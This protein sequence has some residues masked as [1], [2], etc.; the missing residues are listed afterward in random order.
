MKHKSEHQRR[1]E[2]DQKV[3]EKL[4]RCKEILR[5]LKQVA[6]AI[7]GGVDSS[8]LLTLATE[9]LGSENVLA[10]TATDPIF[11]QQE[12]KLAR[13]IAENL[14]VEL[15]E[16]RA[17]QLSNPDFIA[18]HPQRCYLCKK[19][20]LRHIKR[21]ADERNIHTIITGSNADDALE[22]RPG[23]KAERELGVCCPL[24][25]AGL[26]KQEIRQA[27][28]AMGLPNW[29]RAASACLATRI[30][31]GSKITIEKLT[32][33]EKGEQILYEMGFSLVRLRDHNHIA[34]IEIKPE[35]FNEAIRK[36]D[37][38]V[39]SLSQLGYIYITLDLAGYHSGSMDWA[40]KERD[41]GNELNELQK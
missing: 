34:R 14:G 35:Q 17:G 27:A 13:Q 10:A 19:M 16:F 36:R 11:P 9:T 6:V 3:S 29:N 25:Q 33:I 20:M 24:E 41:T 28:R 23:R 32:R 7:S 40:F 2:I 22:H 15:I 18:N 4:C 38:I 21:I 8:L 1:I 30:P 5:P 26:T 31:Y 12:R 39:N 37:E